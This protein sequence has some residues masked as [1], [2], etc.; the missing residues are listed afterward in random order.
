[1]LRAM[2]LRELDHFLRGLPGART[3]RRT[4]ADVLE[5]EVAA[6]HE[7]QRAGRP[8]VVEALGSAEL[9]VAEL[10]QLVAKGHYFADWAAAMAAGATVVDPRFEAA[11]DAI[12]DGDLTR[13]QELLRAAPELAR[14]R[15]PFGHHQ[16][17]LQHVSANGIEM[18]RQWQTP[19]NAVA[20]AEALLAA[21]SEPD[22]TCDSYG[23][24]STALTLLVS[25]AHPYEAGVQGQLVEALCRGGANPDGL[26]EH[27][28]PLWTAITFGYT[29]A[30]EALAR[31]GARVDNLIFA[32]AL[33]DLERVRSFFGPA[34]TLLPGR[35]RS[36][37]RIGNWGPALDPAHTL[38]YALIYATAHGRRE[39]VE[40]LLGKHPDLD[41]IEPVWKNTALSAARFHKRAELVALLIEAADSSSRP[42]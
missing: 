33:G 37:E 17:L 34:G 16:T 36:G 19:A 25:S 6:L 18:N 23:N 26:D 13:L 28:S 32:A 38:E 2:L 12:V 29:A 4:L 7:A 27:A 8:E 39:V 14:A 30:A 42:A 41:V 1:M 15:S 24:G 3:E 21:G 10:G 22:V 20:I 40:L 35:A 5:R 11:A 31:S 9:P